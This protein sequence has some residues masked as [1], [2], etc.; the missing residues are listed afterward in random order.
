MSWT[1]RKITSLLLSCC[2]FKQSGMI[3]I[4]LYLKCWMKQYVRIKFMLLQFLQEHI[5]EGPWYFPWNIGDV[6]TSIR[7]LNMYGLVLTCQHLCPS[8]KAKPWANNY[9]FYIS[10]VNMGMNFLFRSHLPS[11]SWIFLL[12]EK[13]CR[14]VPLEFKSVTVFNMYWRWEKLCGRVY[15]WLVWIQH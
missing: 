10:L 7:T 12:L 3:L 2:F 9:L 14:H 6:S 1:Y 8:S 5:D 15:E 11:H 4:M 13:Y